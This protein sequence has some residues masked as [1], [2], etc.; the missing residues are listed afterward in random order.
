MLCLGE[1]KGIHASAKE[2]AN[3]HAFASCAIKAMVCQGLQSP[4]QD[5]G[6]K[7]IQDK[8]LKNAVEQLPEIIAIKNEVDATWDIYL[9]GYTALAKTYSHI[10]W[11]AN[12]IYQLATGQEK[13]HIEEIPPLWILEG[14]EKHN[15]LLWTTLMMLCNVRL[16]LSTM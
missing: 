8:E 4:S 10:L 16:L 15:F 2:V 5:E 11:S 6:S 1:I 7:A 3:K 13:N 9:E 14:M 12:K